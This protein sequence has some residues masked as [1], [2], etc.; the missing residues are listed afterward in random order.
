[1]SKENYG[2]KAPEN[3]HQL[4]DLLSTSWRRCVSGGGGG[5]I[6]I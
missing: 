2:G 5:V 3:F 1:M 6:M 4:P